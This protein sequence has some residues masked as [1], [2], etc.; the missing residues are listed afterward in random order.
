MADDRQGH[1]GDLFGG[2]G[3]DASPEDRERI[4]TLLRTVRRA[5]TGLYE[6]LSTDPG[7]EGAVRR[8]ARRLG[9][10]KE[11]MFV[12]LGRMSARRGAADVAR[13]LSR[14]TG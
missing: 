8:A 6:T 1:A 3:V 14:A 10:A 7:D 9:A 13:T 4:R 5:R 2:E 12:H 11:E